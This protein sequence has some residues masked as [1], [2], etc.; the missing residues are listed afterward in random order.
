MTA[1]IHNSVTLKSYIF[2]RFQ[3]IPF[4]LGSILIEESA[5]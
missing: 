3:Q 2:V 4:K 1:T 5:M